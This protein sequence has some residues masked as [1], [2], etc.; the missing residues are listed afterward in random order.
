[1]TWNM[2]VRKPV[3]RLNNFYRADFELNFISSEPVI[4][5]TQ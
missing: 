3:K 5:N 2:P 4:F 1:M